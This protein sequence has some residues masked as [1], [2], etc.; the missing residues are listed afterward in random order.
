MPEISHDLPRIEPS[1][2]SKLPWQKPG[3]FFLEQQFHQGPRSPKKV[4]PSLGAWA[5]D[6]LM[7]FIYLGICILISLQKR[8]PQDFSTLTET[9]IPLGL[10]LSFLYYWSTW[11]FL[12][13]S[14]GEWTWG[15]ELYKTPP[16]LSLKLLL[17][18]SLLSTIQ[19]LSLGLFTHRKIFK[20]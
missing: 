13:A 1:R 10:T 7:I 15:Q 3:D 18:L 5:L 11:S 6:N 8:Q 20:G 16:K 14:V 4:L 2:K 19:T 12:G 9:L 17:S